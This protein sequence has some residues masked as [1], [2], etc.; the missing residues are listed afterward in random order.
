MSGFRTS[1]VSTRLLV[2]IAAICG[3]LAPRPLAAQWVTG[4]YSD[5]NAIEGIASIPWRNYTHVNHF[6][7]AAGIGTNGIGN[8]T[9]SL[10]YIEPANIPTFVAAAHAARKLALVTIMDNPSQPYAFAQDATPA[11]V[12]TFAANIAQFVRDHGYDGVDLDWEQ[13]IVPGEYQ[14]L[15]SALRD[16]LPSGIITAAMDPFAGLPDVAAASFSMLDQINIMCYDMDK[17]H[18]YSWYDDALFQRGNNAVMSCDARIAPFLNAGVPSAKIGVGMPFYGRRWTG[19]NQ[20]LQ[21]GWTATYTILYNQLVRDPTRWQPRYMY[22]DGQY[23]ASFLSIPELN[24]FVT[25]TGPQQ[26]QNVVAWAKGRNFGGFM[27]FAVEYEYLADQIGDGRYPLS[28][29]LHNALGDVTA[30][31][32]TDA[33]TTVSAP[34]TVVVAAPKGV[35]S[36]YSPQTT[37]TVATD[38]PAVCRYGPSAGIPFSALPNGFASTGATLHSSVLTNLASGTAYTYYLKCADPVT[39]VASADYPVAFSTAAI[40][41]AGPLPVAVTPAS[42][43]G[44]AATFA[45]QVSDPG[46]FGAINQVDLIVD[47]PWVGQPNSCWVSFWVPSKTVY[48]KSDDNSGWLAA[49]LGAPEGLR[50]RQC[51]L[52]TSAMS[53]SGSG[54]VLTVQFPLSFLPSYAGARKLFVIAGDKSGLSSGWQTMGLWNVQ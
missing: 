46:G 27:T 51:A 12:A 6:A 37:L 20:A 54:N 18:G 50:N 52:D 44:S 19:V 26:I 17:W 16:R 30:A 39:G 24:E 8:G 45:V 31:G 1:P 43:A 53:V 47:T 40:P 35:L 4:Y 2:V 34:P 3:A 29:A 22:Y 33:G 48:L 49:Q 25:Y 28:S 36:G 13:N 42:G 23:K 38:I 14:A 32:A 41:D 21:T 11:L 9:V 7:A 15:L 5:Q 10:N